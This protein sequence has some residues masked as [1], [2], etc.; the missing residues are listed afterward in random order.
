MLFHLLHRGVRL[1]LQAE[2]LA[3][4]LQALQQE[5]HILAVTYEGEQQQSR[6]LQDDVTQLQVSHTRAKAMVSLVRIGLL[7]MAYPN[8]Y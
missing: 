5:H 1:W 3:R 6:L 2:Q 7:Y 8:G 4:D